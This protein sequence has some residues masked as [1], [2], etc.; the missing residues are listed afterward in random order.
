MGI[1]S[2]GVILGGMSVIHRIGPKG[3]VVIPKPLR[4]ALG[5]EPGDEV[6]FQLVDG[7]A[8]QIEPAELE[9]GRG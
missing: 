7:K 9:Q 2:G 3:Q 4:D 1:G 5:L 8:V 6:E